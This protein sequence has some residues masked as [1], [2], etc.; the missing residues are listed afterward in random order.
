MKKKGK[1]QLKDQNRAWYRE[2]CTYS[3]RREKSEA[4]KYL[5]LWQKF[6]IPKLPTRLSFEDEKWIETLPE[7]GEENVWFELSGTPVNYY[8]TLVENNE[9]SLTGISGSLRLADWQPL[10][11]END[12]L[13]IIYFKGDI[14]QRADSV[15]ISGIAEKIRLNGVDLSLKE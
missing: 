4:R 11:L 14:S 12:D 5:K 13:N 9:I 2:F 6:F 8:L 1:K 10:K 15:S 7:E 3:N